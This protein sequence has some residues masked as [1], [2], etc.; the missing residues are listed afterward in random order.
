MKWR[1]DLIA[2]QWSLIGEEQAFV[3]RTGR[4]G[5]AIGAQ[6]ICARIVERLMRLCFLYC[7]R[8]APYSKWFG[9]AFARLP[10]DEAIG[11][12]MA[13]AL[14]TGN[15]DERER[16]LVAAQLL[17]VDLHNRCDLVLPVEA[18]V[19]N[20]HTR[21][22]LVIHADRIA[23][24]VAAQLAGTALADTPL[25]GSMSQI[26]NF[27]ALSDD[28]ARQAQIEGLYAANAHLTP[29][30]SQLGE[31]RKAGLAAESL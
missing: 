23:G 3:T 15:V 10:I 13:L 14:A 22:I 29:G 26:G 9:T 12:E 19:Q 27:V 16:H 31:G 1:A 6:I 11:N 8:Y 28:P 20:Y 17:V 21:P 24:S 4:R 25:I 7:R 18:H 2:S 30:P 5:D